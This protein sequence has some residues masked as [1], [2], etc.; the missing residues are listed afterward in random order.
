M[1]CDYCEKE[2]EKGDSY[3]KFQGERF[4]D[5]CFE[6]DVVTEYRVGGEFL[7]TDDDGAEEFGGYYGEEE[8]E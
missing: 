5:A 6:K 8:A 2:M 4:C 1:K 7:A 3:M